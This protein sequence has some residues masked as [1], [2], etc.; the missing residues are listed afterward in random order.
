MGT[1]E[2][3]FP[4]GGQAGKLLKWRVRMK[5]MVSAGRILFIYQNITPGS[6][7][8]KGPEK[9]YRVT[10]FGRVTKLLAKEGDIVQPG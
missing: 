8:V 9:K 10:E 6:E 7:D 1:I 5:T 3:T 4:S 2:V